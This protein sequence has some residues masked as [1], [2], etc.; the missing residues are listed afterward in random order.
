MMNTPMVCNIACRVGDGGRWLRAQ[1]AP[2]NIVVLDDY[3]DA[4]C[5]LECVKQFGEVPLK[6]YTN[7]VK[8]VGQ[9]AVR[10]RDAQIL[11]LIGA[12]TA[13]TRA[14]LEKLP[15]L[16]MV[17]QVGA[18]GAHIDVA[19]CTEHGVAVAEALAPLAPVACAE[20]TWALVLAAQRRLPQ[21]IGNLKHGAWQHSGLRASS[22]LPNF[23]I[24]QSLRG[25]ILGVWGYGQVGR[26][27]AGYGRAFGMN[28]L[29][30]GSESARERAQREGFQPAVSREQLL[31]Y[32]DVLSLH[33]RLTE[34]TRAMIGLEDL[35]L[36]K[37]SALLVNTSCAE[38]IAPDALVIAL[39]RGR[40]G[41][42][43]ID[44]F[45]SEPIL[46]GHAL[47]R[48]ENCICTPHIGY[49]EQDNYEQSFGVAFENIINYL[50]NEPTNII[51]PKALEVEHA[52]QQPDSAWGG[53]FQ[54]SH[55]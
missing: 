41:M 48:L 3:Q 4:V 27:V 2:M 45:E 35:G 30:W 15:H 53:Y 11:M 46:Q 13:I 36:M 33:V 37:P 32:S 50:N 39:N 24:G 18:V 29:V 51:N 7:T 19:A 55:F 25:R 34:E 23:R 54:Q 43:A 42:A 1:C 44:V 38:L 12:R 52:K 8:G 28:V 17:S 49:V 31:V 9:L 26:L 21:Y 10:L 20:L 5:R 16:R 47:L 22:M 14:L 6:V 40:P